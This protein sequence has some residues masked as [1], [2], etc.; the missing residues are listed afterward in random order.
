MQQQQ[1]VLLMLMLMLMLLM[2]LMLLVQQLLLQQ[3]QEGKQLK[4]GC[5]Q[6]CC[7]QLQATQ[8]MQVK[9]HVMQ[10]MRQCQLR[11]RAERLRQQR[12]RRCQLRAQVMQVMRVMRQCQLRGM[13]LARRRRRRTWILKAST[14][15][16]LKLRRRPLPP[17]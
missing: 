5:Q 15:M 9:Q 12:A 10:V 14:S 2:L 16:P 6:E 7:K 4:L 11:A 13:R 8:V 1:L 3:Q 17:S